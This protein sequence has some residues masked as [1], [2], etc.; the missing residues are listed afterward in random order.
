MQENIN[1]DLC[2]K[3][4]Y[5]NE[6]IPGQQ[7]LETHKII[8]HGEPTKRFKDIALVRAEISNILTTSPRDMQAREK[9]ATV[10]R[11]AFSHF[12]SNGSFFFDK[13]KREGYWFDVQ[14]KQ[15]MPLDSEKFRSFLFVRLEVNQMDTPFDWILSELKDRVAEQAPKVEPHAYSY[16]DEKKSVLYVNN[17]P[18]RVIRITPD[19]VEEIDNGEGCLFLWDE[20]WEEFEIVKS[21]GIHTI[22]KLLY[23]EYSL[24]ASKEALGLEELTVLLDCY[25]Q[26]VFFRS[27][28]LHRPLL[29][30]IG[31]FACGK[32]TMLVLIGIVLFGKNFEVLG[33]EEQKQDAAVAYVTNSVFG[34]FDNADE[35]IKW[36]PDLLARIVT[37][38]KIPRRKLYTTNT[39]VKYPADCLLGITAR[40]THWARPD[41]ISRALIV[42]FKQPETWH[43]EQKTKQTVIEHRNELISSLIIRAQEIIKRLEQ[44]KSEQYESPSRLASFYSFGMRASFDS[45]L[46][47]VAF[48][49]AL[50][51]QNALAAEEEEILLAVIRA[52]R[53]NSIGERDIQGNLKTW[54]DWKTT[55]QLLAELNQTAKN[56]SIEFTFRANQVG[57]L[58]RRIKENETMFRTEGIRFHVRH[59]ERG[60]EWCFNI[61]A[62]KIVE[63]RPSEVSVPSGQ[64]QIET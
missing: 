50:S 42:K 1:C 9:Y 18:G 64:S 36:L 2:G 53:D 34:V 15:L 63:D 49:K 59:G 48:S 61:P 33:L 45:A 51:I 5:P 11:M 23:S 20:D 38:Q 47:Q 26:S 30:H 3:E 57:S 17:K 19:N 24:D 21:D 12:E 35:R 52:W 8:A 37:R 13:N 56:A 14:S 16:F 54:T 41:I 44:T 39:L 10:S 62:K 29:A 7:A 6:A 32:T 31:P 60:T 43:D 55:T 25:V 46:F 40:T 28:V 27:I 4:L 22:E 58:T